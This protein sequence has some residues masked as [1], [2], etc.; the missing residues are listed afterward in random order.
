MSQQSGTAM[1]RGDWGSAA[2]QILAETSPVNVGVQASVDM[3]TN[4]LT[5]DV[6]VYYTGTQTVSSNKL[7][8]A[9]VQNGILGPQSGGASYNPSAIDPATGLLSLIH[10]SEPTRPY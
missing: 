9:I 5:V 7:N 3:A 4:T 6:E 1:S 2:S 8:V 10:I